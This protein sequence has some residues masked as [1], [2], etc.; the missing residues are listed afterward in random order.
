MTEKHLVTRLYHHFCF[1]YT[2]TEID[3]FDQSDLLPLR[4]SRSNQLVPKVAAV[5]EHF[6]CLRDATT[7]RSTK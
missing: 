1:D 6:T 3:S 7:E 2:A 4:S 5:S